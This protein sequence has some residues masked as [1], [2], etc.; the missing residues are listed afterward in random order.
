MTVIVKNQLNFFMTYDIS[1]IFTTLLK[2]DGHDEK[3]AQPPH[4]PP[5]SETEIIS[6]RA[7]RKL[8]GG[9]GFSPDAEEALTALH[10]NI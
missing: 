1:Q 6:S 10:T 8:S 3:E 5:R 4:F 2:C 7:G 9:N